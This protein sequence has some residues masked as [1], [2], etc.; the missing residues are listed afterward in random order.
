MSGIAWLAGAV[1]CAA[2]IEDL[3]R[4]VIPN[5]IPLTALASGAA[6]QAGAKGWA[7]LGGALLGACAGL[8]IFLVF[9]VLRGMGGGD[10]KLMA[11]FGALL[12][13]K[14]ILVAAF[15][16][17]GLGALIALAALGAGLLRSRRLESI[18]YAPAIVGGAWLALLT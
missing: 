18:P 13:P 15:F 3:R 2:L 7:G 1:G 14:L 6:W 17:A 12:G 11:G 8:L 5:W 16:A 9:Y 10:I 4:R